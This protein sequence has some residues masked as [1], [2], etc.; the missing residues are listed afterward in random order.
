[1]L[2]FKYTTNLFA[3]D[4]NGWTLRIPFGYLEYYKFQDKTNDILDK[5]NKHYPKS[6]LSVTLYFGV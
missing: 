3:S 6:M 2:L 1:M 5:F 4:K